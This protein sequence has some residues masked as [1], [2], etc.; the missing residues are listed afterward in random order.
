[1]DNFVPP[2]DYKLEAR[3]RHASTPQQWSPN[4]LSV[5][6]VGVVSCW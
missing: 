2:K 6:S 5:V 1:M 4:T 3:P